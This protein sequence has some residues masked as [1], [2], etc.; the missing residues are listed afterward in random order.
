MRARGTVV[1]LVAVIVVAALMTLLVA[2]CTRH[3]GTGGT[4]AS[5]ELWASKKS[6]I[7]HYPSCTWAKRIHSENLVVFH[8]VKEA[9]DAGYRPCKVCRPPG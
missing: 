1:K 5:L 8:S 9:R 4:G 2:G 7:Y 6:N 3:S